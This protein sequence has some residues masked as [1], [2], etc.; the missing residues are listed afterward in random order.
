[1]MILRPDNLDRVGPML[2]TKRKMRGLSLRQIE[3]RTGIKNTSVN[4][5]EL[6]KNGARL[7]SLVL[8][9]DALGLEIEIREK[10]K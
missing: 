10:K 5:I 6:N 9:A 3:I 7:S 4:N 8:I 1:M 2:Q